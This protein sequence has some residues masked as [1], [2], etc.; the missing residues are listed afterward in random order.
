MFE[1]KQ[2][3]YIEWYRNWKPF[4][5]I[6]FMKFYHQLQD[7]YLTMVTAMLRIDASAKTELPQ[8]RRHSCLKLHQRFFCWKHP[9]VGFTKAPFV[10]F[11]VKEMF[12]LANIHVKL[13]ESLSYLTGVAAAATPAKYEPDIQHVASVLTM[14]KNG[15]ING[16]EEIG[17]VTQPSTSNNS[18]ADCTMTPP[19]QWMTMRPNIT[20]WKNHA[21]YTGKYTTCLSV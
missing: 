1:T 3:P 4:G 21:I 2:L 7:N 12:D 14:L 10:N 9:G 20:V 8:K 17:L 5:F 6:C 16:T 18:K 15:E 19:L 13:L 11:S